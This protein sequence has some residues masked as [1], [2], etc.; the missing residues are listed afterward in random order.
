MT[1]T[2]PIGWNNHPKIGLCT[3]EQIQQYDYKESRRV[4]GITLTTQ[5]GHTIQIKADG[6]STAEKWIDRLRNDGDVVSDEPAAGVSV[7]PTSELKTTVA[8]REK[9]L[10]LIQ[11]QQAI[12]KEVYGPN[13]KYIIGEGYIVSG[14]EQ[15]R[16]TDHR[17]RE[18][19]NP[20][21]IPQSSL[22]AAVRDLWIEGKL[23]RVKRGT[24][25]HY[26]VV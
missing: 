15:R 10:K 3:D 20:L 12:F 16:T 6:W 9:V 24:A 21:P 1:G 17:G 18:N 25:Y 5:G 11:D 22:R 19:G 4:I 26:K 14:L 23:A 13:A 7:T 2:L 8:L